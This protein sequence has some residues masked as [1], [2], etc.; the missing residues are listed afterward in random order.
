MMASAVVAAV[1]VAPRS[2]SDTNSFRDR[3]HF[4]TH[5]RCCR[6]L[7]EKAVLK[8]SL[9]ILLAMLSADESKL[10][11]LLGTL[12]ALLAFGIGLVFWIRRYVDR[13][14]QE[15]AGK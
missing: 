10:I 5:A 12:A 14:V 2:V 7:K 4:Q 11:W 9:P 8:S 1:F 13:C 6:S 15:R 3:L